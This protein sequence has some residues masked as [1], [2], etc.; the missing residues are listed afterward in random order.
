MRQIRKSVFET[1]SSSTHSICI[2][3]ERDIELNIP[4]DALHFYCGEFGWEWRALRTTEDK[5]SYLYSSILTVYGNK[6]AEEKKNVLFDM[7]GEDGIECVFEEP[8]Y[9]QY[10][11]YVFCDNAS[12]DHA[13][14]GEHKDFVESVLRNKRRLYRYLFSSQSFVLTGNDNDYDRDVSINVDYKHDE[15]H[16]GN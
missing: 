15:Y 6:E 14:E 12:I 8:K 11:N 3:T 4:K 2:T 13:G 5:A 16:K 7:L 1:N 10:G 9:N